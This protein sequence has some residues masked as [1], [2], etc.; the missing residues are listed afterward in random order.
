MEFLVN[1]W[2]ISYSSARIE[3]THKSYY[4][5]HFIGKFA[6]SAKGVIKISWNWSLKSGNCKK[7]FR[8]T[9]LGSGKSERCQKYAGMKIVE[10]SIVQHLF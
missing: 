4:C 6:I 2:L 7:I 3:F 9:T 8:I 1:N 5:K 10:M